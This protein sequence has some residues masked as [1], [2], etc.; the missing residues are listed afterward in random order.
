MIEWILI[1]V[2]ELNNSEQQILENQE[3]ILEQLN[4]IKEQVSHLGAQLD[5]RVLVGARS[6][7]RHL[8]DGMNSETEAVRNDEFRL[9]R[10]EFNKLINLNPEENT[11]GTSGE[12]SNV[13][14][15]GLGYWGNFHYF[16][17][18]GEKRNSLMQVYEC[19]QKYARLGLLLFSSKFFS[20][21]YERL[22]EENEKNL[23][24]VQNT[25]SEKQGENFWQGLSYYMKQTLRVA[26]TGVVGAGGM[27]LVGGT[28]GFLAP[29]I[30]AAT[31]KTFDAM[32]P[33]S[34]HYQDISALQSR[35]TALAE[36]NEKYFVEVVEESKVR[37]QE[38]RKCT[39]D[40]LIDMAKKS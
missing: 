19:T 28:G 4:E 7:L 13:C 31:K 22:I 20:K 8:V 5:E 11:Q 6:G 32:N 2:D 26:A 36:E 38:L 33:A 14:L 40:K 3:R 16:N 9:A 24:D 37:Q 10:A 25:L 15:I 34:P 27:T 29:A 1:V 17:L 21:D 30:M 35:V 12:V 23:V 18:R 39:L